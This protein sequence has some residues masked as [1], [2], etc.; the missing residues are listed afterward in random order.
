MC[1]VYRITCNICK[2]QYIGESCR[3]LHS[4][5]IEH[6]R[7]A[8]NPET[9]SNRDEAMAVHQR[10]YHTGM[11]PDLSFELL[12]TESNT[13]LRKIYEAYYIM[14][15]KPDINDKEE[16]KQLQKFLVR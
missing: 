16:C 10:Q 3:S 7:Y 8:T 14:N 6:L 4:R 13:I 1:P 11:T 5:L 15:C 2:L 9:P 12:V